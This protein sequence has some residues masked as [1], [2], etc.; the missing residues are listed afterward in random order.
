MLSISFE[1]VREVVVRVAY[2]YGFFVTGRFGRKAESFYSYSSCGRVVSKEYIPK[3]S[4]CVEWRVGAVEC[5]VMAVDERV[6]KD[7]HR[8]V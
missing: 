1:D 3:A 4:R 8:R 2:A 5:N 7:G 6:V